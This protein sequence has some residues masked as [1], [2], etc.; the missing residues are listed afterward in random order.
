VVKNKHY[1]FFLRFL[2]GAVDRLEDCVFSIVAS[3]L[4]TV[5][6]VL[7]FVTQLLT[8]VAH[9]LADVARMLMIATPIAIFEMRLVPF[10][11]SPPVVPGIMFPRFR[12]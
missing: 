4:S 5:A 9:V 12:Q 8:I 7:A 2:A 6:L 10:S 1:F 3:V 11:R